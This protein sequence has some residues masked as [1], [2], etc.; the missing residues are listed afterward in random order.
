MICYNIVGTGKHKATRLNWDVNTLICYLPFLDQAP[1]ESL[2]LQ[3]F[4][5]AEYAAEYVAEM[6]RQA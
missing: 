1:A 6:Y 3:L 5:L 2:Y 4:L